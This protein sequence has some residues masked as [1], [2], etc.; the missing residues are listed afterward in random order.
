MIYWIAIFL[1][2]CS[3]W[4]PWWGPCL[5][6][7]FIGYFSS[8]WKQSLGLPFALYFIFWTSLCCYFDFCSQYLMGQ[9]ITGLLGV[10][11]STLY[12]YSCY[13]FVGTLGGILALSGAPLGYR[14]KKLV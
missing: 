14:L 5:V 7:V 12:L 1:V 3:Y 13:L 6:G 9:R 10:P 4:L 8:S 11:S 2:L